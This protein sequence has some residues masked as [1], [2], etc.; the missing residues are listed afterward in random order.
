MFG[1]PP[2]AELAKTS[3]TSPEF[4]RTDCTDCHKPMIWA[5]NAETKKRVPLS[6]VALVYAVRVVNGATICLPAR[7]WVRL[8]NERM[9]ALR[10]KVINAGLMSAEEFD[11]LK[12]DSDGV[13]FKVTHFA[14]CPHAK[15]FSGKNK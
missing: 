8:R 4:K 15:N 5:E 6:D 3:T 7:D 12:L 2:V 14:D 9:K 11:A 13:A 10:D 1:P